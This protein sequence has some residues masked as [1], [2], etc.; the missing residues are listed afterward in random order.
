MTT[1]T[2]QKVKELFDAGVHYG[3]RK[4]R[5]HPSTMPFV[6]GAK[7]GVELFDLEKTTE[8]LEKAKEFVRS[9]GSKKKVILFVSGKYEA[10]QAIKNGAES[11]NQPY[12]VDRW[13]GGTITNFSQMKKR[14]SRY[15][16]LVAQK[17]KGELVKYT[18]KEQLLLDREM[19]SLEDKFGGIVDMEKLPDALFVIDAD[20]E[21]TAVREAR[22]KNIPVVALC[23]TDCNMDAVDYPIPGNDVARSSIQ[24]IVSEIVNAY[25]EGQKEAPAKEVKKEK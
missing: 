11:I 4:A 16:D 23:N 14:T 24:Y 17:E 2:E 1:N 22:R 8:A 3:Y 21:V 18:K 20:E 13:V 19:R 9:L 7:D 25:Q 15:H 6:Y 10:K 5:R 12:V